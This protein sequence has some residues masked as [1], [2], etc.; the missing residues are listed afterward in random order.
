MGKQTLADAVRLLEDSVGKEKFKAFLNQHYS[1]S[2]HRG[3]QLV[4]LVVEGRPLS[5][6]RAYKTF[7]NKPGMYSSKEMKAFKNSV[8]A[9]A[10][11][12]GVVSPYKGPLSL[13]FNFYY[14][15]KHRSRK[16]LAGLAFPDVDNAL[17][18]LKD[19][20]EEIL[21]ENDTQVQKLTARK[22]Y[23]KNAP[24][25]EITLYRISKEELDHIYNDSEYEDLQEAA[26]NAQKQGNA[27]NTKED[28]EIW[29]QK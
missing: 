13:D 27:A 26:A 14:S 23:S 24:R 10:V 28:F 1:F 25:S 12:K 6:N 9:A 19:A 3:E 11:K 16:S 29:L 8:Y 17:K 18:P 15:R 20:L 22:Y 5:V 21:F 7:K 2:E 4:R